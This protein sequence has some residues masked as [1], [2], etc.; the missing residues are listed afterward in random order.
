MR[1]RLIERLKI[2]KREDLLE[3]FDFHNSRVRDFDPERPSVLW[4]HDL[5]GDPEYDHL[6]VDGGA[7]FAAM[8]FVSHWQ[9]Q[10]F[11]MYYPKL[12]NNCHI[13]ENA[14]DNNGTEETAIRKGWHKG[15]A[16]RSSWTNSMVQSED[17]GLYNGKHGTINSPIR[18]IYHTTPHRGLQLLV[19]VYEQLYNEYKQKNVHLHLDV[20]SSFSIYGWQ[21]RDEP[22]KEVFQRCHDH[23]G[24]TYHGARPNSDVIDALEKAHIFAF[25]SIW[26]ETS[27][28]AMIEALDNHVLCVHPN[29]GALP[30]TAAGNTLMY[31]FVSDYQSHAMTFYKT[32]QEAIDGYL[33]VTE[34]INSQDRESYHYPDKGLT[35]LIKR[36]MEKVRETHS[37]NVFTDKWITL[38]D[39][40]LD[41]LT[42][43]D[44]EK[45]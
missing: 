16:R 27:C 21:A 28:L 17:A 26:Q 36:G 18:L 13:I 6:K 32:M 41:D 20:Y 37:L 15:T 3:F 44:D 24:I 38:L 40:I 22:Y 39:R 1:D 25:P 23:P 5:P 14:I 45:C 7:R 4:V 43:S 19:P 11:A 29:L 10:Q 31:P 35:R 8:V 30:E 42:K 34:Y 9:H 2:R 12:G 33:E